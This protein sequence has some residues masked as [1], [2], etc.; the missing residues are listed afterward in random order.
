[1][2]IRTSGNRRRKDADC[3]RPPR[4]R[5]A[6]VQP[7]P[8]AGCPRPPFRA[9]FRF[10]FTRQL[11]LGPAPD[12]RVRIRVAGNGRRL[13]QRLGSA[14][15]P[16]IVMESAHS[17]LRV[18]LVCP[19]DSGN[20]GAVCRAA[21]TMGITSVYLVGMRSIDLGEARARA[22]HARDVLDSSIR[23]RSLDRALADC[24]LVA[25]IT[26]RLG[27]RRKHRSY[28]PEELAS[29]VASA[30]SGTVALV[31]GNEESGLTDQEL[32]RC[33]MAV[34][35]PSSMMFPSLN[36]SHAVQIIAYELFKARSA[37]EIPRDYRPAA[38][39]RLDSLIRIISQ[40]LANIGL[41][42]T[43]GRASLETLLRDIFV[44]G[45][46][47]EPESE[48]IEK[49]FRDISGVIARKSVRG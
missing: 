45:E 8:L 11:P 31:F 2:R 1:M 6:P 29:K 34:S 47:T 32:A 40:S 14:I 9:S 17:S 20:V 36:L 22:H 23:C 24:E 44:R 49:I 35:I 15:L 30:R 46:V 7:V 26:R 42:R 39:G 43:G 18:V 12:H 41:F 19:R 10:R 27:R 5:S 25:G 21:K 28:T 4:V 37:H 16:E 13:S 38:A 3:H 33:H 48:R